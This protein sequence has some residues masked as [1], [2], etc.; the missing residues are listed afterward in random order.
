MSAIAILLVVLAVGA[1]AT[2]VHQA[3]LRQDAEDARMAAE[4]AQSESDDARDLAEARREQ[5]QANLYFS[6][7]YIAGES[8]NK[9]FGADT[10]AARLEDWAPEKT[11][12]DFRGWEWH[13]LDQVSRRARVRSNRLRKDGEYRRPM[14]VACRVRDEFV[15]AV[16]N[17]GN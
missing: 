15:V 12:K 16:E 6:Q 17:W 5:M 3:Q 13:Y 9:P 2:A 8:L 11:E 14:S 1:T 4:R 10:I 7:M